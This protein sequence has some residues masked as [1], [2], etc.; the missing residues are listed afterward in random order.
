MLPN[1]QTSSTAI[2]AAYLPPDDFERLNNQVVDRELGGVGL[3]DPSSGLAVHVWRAEYEPG[4]GI[5][6]TNETTLFT[7]VYVPGVVVQE[8]SLAFD[9]NMR[10][11]LAY[12]SNGSARLVWFDSVVGQEVTTLLGAD[13]RNPLLSLDDKRLELQYASDIILAYIRGTSLYWRAQRER[14][15]VEHFG[16]ALPSVTDRLELLG[17]GLNAANRLQFRIRAVF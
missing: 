4:V 13:V 5:R 15:L 9:Q 14:F 7:V 12:V 8:V 17:L 2:R 10:P 6:L 1:E 11:A 3:N 16:G